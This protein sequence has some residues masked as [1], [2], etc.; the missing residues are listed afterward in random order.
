MSVRIVDRDN[1]Y[2]A[3][4]KRVFGM[5]KLAIATG[6]L[7]K[8]GQATAA[9]SKGKLTLVE[10]ATFNEF[11]T[12]DGHVP[13]RSFIRAWFDAEEP[14]LR[15]MLVTL[16]QRAIKGDMTQKQ[17][18]DQMGAYCVGAIQ[19]RI[20]DGIPP[21]NAPRTIARKHSSKPLI[22]TG[23]LRSAISYEIRE[24]GGES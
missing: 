19:Q 24:G 1:G 15:E 21:E 20:A 14:K 17:V 8:D 11:G 3:L 5:K 13:E 7:A 10:V 16:M 6:I 23:Q 18:L 9:G 12:S 2:A 4:V 22:N